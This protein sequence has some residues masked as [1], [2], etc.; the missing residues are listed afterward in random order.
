MTQL[1]ITNDSEATEALQAVLAYLQ[2]RRHNES[3]ADP[4][5]F[6]HLYGQHGGHVKAADES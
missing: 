1:E 6:S 3:G 5:D 2:K 4:I